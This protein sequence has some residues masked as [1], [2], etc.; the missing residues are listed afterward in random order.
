M[1]ESDQYEQRQ[2]AEYA[3]YT[4]E[5]ANWIGSMGPEEFLRMKELGLLSPVSDSPVLGPG[6]DHDAAEDNRA[7]E[8]IDYAGLI[9]APEKRE[10][11]PG[12]LT[13]ETVEACWDALRR[14]V[15][16]LMAQT[17]T[18]LALDCF[19]LAS[20]IAFVGDTQT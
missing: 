4:E 15:G 16:V 14:L 5:Y 13:Q 8:S 11:A 17:N 7:S 18:R 6:M 19:A 20:G 2:D 12:E 1:R 3:R 9:D 10:Q